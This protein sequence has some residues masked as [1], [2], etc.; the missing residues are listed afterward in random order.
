MRFTVYHPKWNDQQFPGEPHMLQVPRTVLASF[1]DCL[2]ANNISVN[3]RGHYMK[4][5]RFYLDFCS[6][7]RHDTN[8][9]DSIIAFQKKASGKK[10]EQCLY[11]QFL[12]KN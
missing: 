12:F 10:T 4:W 1:E 7:Y 3:I 6:K 2:V 9:S 11:P 8:N 5:L